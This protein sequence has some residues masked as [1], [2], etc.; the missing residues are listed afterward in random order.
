MAIAP[1]LT[2]LT[3]P[4]GT[5][6]P[7]TPQLGVNLF[8]QYLAITGLEELGGINFGATTPASDMRDRPW[9]KTDISGNPIGWFSWNGSTWAQI[10][11]ASPSGTTANRPSS[12]VTGQ[13]YFDTDINVPLIYERSAWRTQSGSPGDVKEVYAA[14]LADALTANPGWVQD[15]ASSKRVVAAADGTTGYNC[16]DTA[17]SDSTTLTTAQ[18]PEFSLT[19]T[20]PYGSSADNGDQGPYIVT[21]EGSPTAS[22]AFDGQTNTIGEG[23]AIDNRQ[24]TIYYWRLRK[25]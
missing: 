22:R 12:A 25:S 24:G 20:A 1:T 4:A 10:L 17:G 8:S 23:E 5:E 14:T 19:V 21:S 6:W 11:F 3:L 15:T 2:P 13:L 18:L 7:G 9:F 16:G